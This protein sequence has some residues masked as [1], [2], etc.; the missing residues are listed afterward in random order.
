[1]AAKFFPD[2]KGGADK[3]MKEHTVCLC[4]DDNDLEMAMTCGHA[5]IPEVSS[6]S[7]KEIVDRYP[8][9]FSQT[10]GEGTE[11]SG[12]ESTEVAL[13]LILQKLDGSKTETEDDTTDAITEG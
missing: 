4:D 12:P 3:M 1:L 13:K 7:M 11:L 5:Y 2:K 9:H 6:A 8:D 10:G